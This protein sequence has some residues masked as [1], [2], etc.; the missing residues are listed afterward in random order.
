MKKYFLFFILVLSLCISIATPASAVPK[1]SIK[2]L[3][4]KAGSKKKMKI[5][6][7]PQKIIWKTSKKSVATVNK[8]GVVRAKK[9]GSAKITSKFKYEGR[10]RKMHCKILVCSMNTSTMTLKKGTTATVNIHGTKKET[11]VSS[12]PLVATVSKKGKIKAVQTGSCTITGKIENLT[13]KRKIIVAG[14]KPTTIFLSETGQAYN[15]SLRNVDGPVIYR[16]SNEQVA[17]V[18][19]EKLIPVGKGTCKVTALADGNIY[20][21]PVQVK[22]VSASQFVEYL[23]DYHQYILKHPERFIRKYDSSLKDFDTVRARVAVGK[24]IGITCVV[25]CRWG[26]YALGIRRSDGKALLSCNNGTFKGQYTGGMKTAFDW[27]NS[28]DDEGGE[29][30]GL[31]LK[32]A[33]DKGYLRK[34]DIIGYKKKTHTFVYSGDGYLVYEGGTYCLRKGGHY[35]DGIKMHYAKDALRLKQD[36]ISEIMRWKK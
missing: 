22:E 28:E 19:D 9:I 5:S 32:Q 14:F 29:A 34:G 30:I 16:S 27:I 11:W 21:C 17:R 13:F 4:M 35:R 25:P 10:I 26:L 3:Y 31:T 18:S 20:T 7:K 33:V 12:D 8:K 6:G 24:T 1:T 23:E 15:L 2:K 36:K